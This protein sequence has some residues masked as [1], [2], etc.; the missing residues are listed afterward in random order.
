MA[1]S[2]STANHR[3]TFFEYPDLT[4]IRGEPDFESLHKLA[5]ELKA[6]A[7]SVFSNL[8][9]GLHG[10][11]GLVLDVVEYALLTP[12]PFTRPVHPGPLVI[13]PAST[14][15]MSLTIKASHTEEIRVFREVYAVEKALLQQIIKAVE[16]D[17]LSA[18]RNR[19]TN[20]ITISV[21]EVLAHLILMGQ[22]P[23]PYPQCLSHNVT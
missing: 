9:G 5:N 8:G 20:S 23:L 3:T 21:G 13:D 16:P 11:L 12:T 14:Q 7:Q 15:H 17:Y 19:E 10:H 2:S 1:E 6:N 22:P 4:Q 18:V